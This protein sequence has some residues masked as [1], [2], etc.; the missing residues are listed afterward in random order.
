MLIII[1]PKNANKCFYSDKKMIYI[2]CPKCGKRLLEGDIG[3]N[4]RIKCCNCESIFSAQILS[5]GVLIKPK[6]KFAAE[7][8]KENK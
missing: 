4:V 2:N 7:E 8:S 6:D 5:E 1:R 3:S